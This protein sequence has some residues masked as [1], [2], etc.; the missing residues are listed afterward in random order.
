MIG[1]GIHERQCASEFREF[2]AM[3]QQKPVERLGGGAD[4][5]GML[6][7][8]VLSL[9]DGAGDIGPV[10]LVFTPHCMD[11]AL[12]A[13]LLQ[14]VFYA[15]GNNRKTPPQPFQFAAKCNNCPQIGPA[16]D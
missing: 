1:L 15:A 12:E 13:C 6:A 7:A 14:R 2:G 8:L 4:T 9:G 10:Q 3:V 11:V 5:K 16:K